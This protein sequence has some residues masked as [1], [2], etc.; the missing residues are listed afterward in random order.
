MSLLA[1]LGLGGLMGYAAS[2]TSAAQYTQ[3]QNSLANQASSNIGYQLGNQS[4]YQQQMSGYGQS[5]ANL[6]RPL[7]PL[8]MIDGR[9]LSME[10]FAD[11]LF[12]V[13]TPERTMFILKYSK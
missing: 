4:L 9:V 3:Y 12:G 13:D 10:Q 7:Q 8:W 2:S 5:I 11:E 1:N 6:G